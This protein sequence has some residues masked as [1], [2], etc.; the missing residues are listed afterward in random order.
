MI[1]CAVAGCETQIEDS[2]PYTICSYCRGEIEEHAKE[3]VTIT[4]I[5]SRLDMLIEQNRKV[6]ELLSILVNLNKPSR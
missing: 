2:C 5:S 6:I 3:P 1:K 4:G